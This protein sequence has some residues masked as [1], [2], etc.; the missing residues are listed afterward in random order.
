MIE[1]EIL[2]EKFHLIFIWNYVKEEFVYSVIVDSVSS[3]NS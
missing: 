1:F 2:S 3:M